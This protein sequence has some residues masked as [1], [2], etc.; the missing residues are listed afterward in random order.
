MLPYLVEILLSLGLF[1]VIVMAAAIAELIDKKSEKNMNDD[2]FIVRQP[3]LSLWKGLALTFA[4][5]AFITLM[6]VSQ[7]FGNDTVHWSMYLVCSVGVLVGVGVVAEYM[8][9]KVIVSGRYI[10]H[11][12]LSGFKKFTF[13]EIIKTKIDEKQIFVILGSEDKELLSMCRTS[14]G[15]AM[16]VS[17]LEQEGI[18]AVSFIKAKHRK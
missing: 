1:V 12:T 15:Y 8:F 16:F 14:R 10:Y 5:I 6:R 3:L 9:W 17:R 11:R 18:S 2:C 13:N 7:A 4:F